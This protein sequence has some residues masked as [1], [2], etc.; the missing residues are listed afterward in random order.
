MKGYKDGWAAMKYK[1]KFSVYP[2]GF[3]VEPAPTSAQTMGWIKSRLIA[4]SKSK[5]RQVA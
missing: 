2:N 5:A 3:K 1:E 4:Y